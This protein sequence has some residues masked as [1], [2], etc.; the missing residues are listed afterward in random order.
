M[1]TSK[2]KN[3]SRRQ[4]QRDLDLTSKRP[5]RPYR[6]PPV[7][8]SCAYCGAPIRVYARLVRKYNYC[9][10]SCF[11]AHRRESCGEGERYCATC[12][13]PVPGMRVYCSPQCSRKS[14]DE[15]LITL[16]CR[17]CGKEF[18]RLLKDTNAEVRKSGLAY[19]SQTCAGLGSQKAI[20]QRRIR[21][22]GSRN[23]TSTGYAWIKTESGWIQEHRVVMEK[24]LGRSLLPDENVHHKNGDKADNRLE[25]LELW[26]TSQP[27][28]Q[29]IGDKVAW[30]V[31]MIQRYNPGLLK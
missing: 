1:E 17:E 7:D 21:P 5:G 27:R 23:V 2:R 22:I 18:Q 29:R 12:N 16:K 13:V 14:P 31:E 3:W 15:E 8:K 19:C 28:G 25:N 11:F 20:T 24:H 10:R 9:G 26:C 30:A 4:A 6:S